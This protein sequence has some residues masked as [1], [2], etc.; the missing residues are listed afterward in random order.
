[1]KINS[2][3]IKPV[4][5][6]GLR[7]VIYSKYRFRMIAGACFYYLLRFFVSKPPV[8]MNN[9]FTQPVLLHFGFIVQLKNCGETQLI[10][11]RTQRTKHV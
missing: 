7:N 6:K 8:R 1:M 4:F 9:G 3:L 5:T 2:T 10:F 11:I